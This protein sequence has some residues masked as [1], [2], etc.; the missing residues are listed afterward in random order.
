MKVPKGQEESLQASFE[1]LTRLIGE[2][3][4][5]AGRRK[6]LDCIV[7]MSIRS[8]DEQRRQLGQALAMPGPG[9]VVVI[10]E[11]LEADTPPDDPE[12]GVRWAVRREFG[13]IV[14]VIGLGV[15]GEKVEV[16]PVVPLL[17]KHVALGSGHTF[18]Q[19]MLTAEAL[20]CMGRFAKPARPALL[21]VRDEDAM[22]IGKT[23]RRA[24]KR[25]PS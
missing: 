4:G 19:R 10:Q 2:E 15:I 16:T 22:E 8:S 9:M 13:K 14:S 12:D 25:I 20:G 11:F 24:L 1:E 21:E 6:F 5:Q 18:Y 3:P 17:I 23:A 7:D